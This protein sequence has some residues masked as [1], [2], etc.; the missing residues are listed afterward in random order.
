MGITLRIL[1]P[2]SKIRA[3]ELMAQGFLMQAAESE[4]IN[5]LNIG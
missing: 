4:T 3:A 1:G 2:R 5:R